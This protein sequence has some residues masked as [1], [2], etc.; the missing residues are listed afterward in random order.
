[1][2]SKDEVNLMEG[3]VPVLTSRREVSWRSGIGKLENRSGYTR[4][5]SMN[6]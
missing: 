3:S 4:M 1:M 6:Y 2:E 5:G